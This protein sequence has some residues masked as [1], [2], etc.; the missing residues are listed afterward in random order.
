MK[1]ET[2]EHIYEINVNA[3]ITFSIAMIVLILILAVL[4][5]LGVI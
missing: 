2:I 4:K 5:Q 3:G 1:K